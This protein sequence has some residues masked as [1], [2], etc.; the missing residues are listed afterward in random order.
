MINKFLID[1][2]H[3]CRKMIIN[4]INLQLIVDDTGV[5]GVGYLVS[6]RCCWSVIFFQQGGMKCFNRDQ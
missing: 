2:I 3:K 6:T 4:L 5:D 1:F